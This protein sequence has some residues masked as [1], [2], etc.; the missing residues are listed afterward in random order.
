[1]AS[2]KGKAFSDELPQEARRWVV[3]LASGEM[4]QPEARRFKKWL[5]ADTKHRDAFRRE[6]R[7]WQE[8]EALKGA[9]AADLQ[10]GPAFP[11]PVPGPA[12]EWDGRASAP[13][14][15]KP[16]AVFRWAA[17]CFFL[18]VLWAQFGS[19]WLADHRTAE[20]ELR[21]VELPD[22]STAHLNTATAMN[23]RYENGM[24]HIQ[25][26]KGEALFDVRRDASRPFRVTSGNGVVEVL[27]TRFGVS[28]SKENLK[29]T[30]LSGEVVVYASSQS[31]LPVAEN[32]RALHLTAGESVDFME[33][34][35]TQAVRKVNVHAALPWTRG[36]IVIDEM[37][38]ADAIA[39]L[40]A[41]FPGRVLILRE[42]AAQQPVSGLFHVDQAESAILALAS[43]QGLRATRITDYL[44]VLR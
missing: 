34:V 4:T 39:K 38:F 21:K 30:V 2:D 9:F 37:P 33:G 28:H 20:G 14:R 12:N 17:A 7:L 3:R 35:P 24:R 15:K 10:D 32:P 36:R 22:G 41:Y 29:V 19:I 23:V 13:L 11:L 40:D 44:L 16:V 18:F 26:L 42:H 43:T 25:L 1:M 31:S 27:G 8:M 5:H 6:R